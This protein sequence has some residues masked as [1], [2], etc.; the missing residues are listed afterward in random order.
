[1]EREVELLKALADSSRLQILDMLSCGPM[2]A[3]EIMKRLDLTQPTISHHMKILVSVGLVDVVKDGKW[4]NYSINK[5]SVNEIVNYII[6][7]TS[8]KED[9][10]CKK[11][12]E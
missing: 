6:Y 9:C 2:C 11:T 7:K 12:L 3:C 8:P 4:M 5:D 1:M 10:I